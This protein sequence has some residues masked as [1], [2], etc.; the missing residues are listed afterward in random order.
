MY[1]F[2]CQ[3]F[4]PETQSVGYFTI[5]YK[6]IANMNGMFNVTVPYKNLHYLGAFFNTKTNA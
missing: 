2:R 4:Y 6:E 1:F 3:L 5:D